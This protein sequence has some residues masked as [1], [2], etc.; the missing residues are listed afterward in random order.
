VGVIHH[1]KLGNDFSDQMSMAEE[2][3]HRTLRNY[4]ANGFGHSAH[5]GGGNVTT[6]KSERNIH[7]CGHRVE[8]AARGQDDSVVTHHEPTIELR[9]LLNGSAKIEIG[10]M[11]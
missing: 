1:P 9:Q 7:L 5:V 10:D 3:H 4:N 6:A 8:V 2:P 11:A